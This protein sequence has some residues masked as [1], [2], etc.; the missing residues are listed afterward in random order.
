MKKCIVILLL[1]SS[2]TVATADFPIP[3]CVFF[4]WSLINEWRGGSLTELPQLTLFGDS[5]AAF[6]GDIHY[7]GNFLGVTKE[8][9]QRK[10]K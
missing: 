8:I 2:I 4:S 9:I 6:V 7:L 10:G 3:P 1:I 5:R